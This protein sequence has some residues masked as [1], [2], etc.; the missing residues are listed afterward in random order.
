MLGSLL[1]LRGDLLSLS[2]SSLCT[3]LLLLSLPALLFAYTL[4]A[5]NPIS[6]FINGNT[7]GELVALSLLTY[8]YT[9]CGNS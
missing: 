3:Q 8:P 7:R 1:P 9:H 2:I 4:S 6:H 5:T